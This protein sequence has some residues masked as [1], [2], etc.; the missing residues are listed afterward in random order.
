MALK[1]NEVSVFPT[2]F[3]TYVLN[4]K[5]TNEQNFV[6]ILNSIADY[7]VGDGFIANDKEPGSNDPLL[8]VIHG[9]LFEIYNWTNNILENGK[10]TAWASIAV[11]D[12]A[13]ATASNALVNYSNKS[14]N[15]DSDGNF[16]GLSITD[17]K[18]SSTQEDFSGHIYSV[19]L[20]EGGRLCAKSFAKFNDNS[21]WVTKDGIQLK[22]KL[23]KV[24]TEIS[25]LDTLT[26]NGGTIDSWKQNKL[27]IAKD[28]YSQNFM[29]IKDTGNHTS[30]IG[31]TTTGGNSLNSLKSKGGTKDN[32]TLIIFDGNGVASNNTEATKGSVTQ[33]V[34]VD[35]GV[36]KPGFKVWASTG[37]PTGGSNGDVW[38]KYTG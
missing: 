15:L 12:G 14:I 5:Y 9:Y 19:Q 30:T 34:Y 20:Y 35:K 26:K 1:S 3:R 37:N 16:Y 18:P 25:K 17:S 7:P 21:I 10:D 22:E 24:D 33:C 38:F 36:I 28:N 8:V 23:D 31:L 11:E 6:N 27:S 13:I 32:P 29:Q 4:G 2:A